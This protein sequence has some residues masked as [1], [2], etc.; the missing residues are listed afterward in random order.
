LV[1][2]EKTVNEDGEQYSIIS[3]QEPS[4]INYTFKAQQAG[5]VYLYI[6]TSE[7]PKVEVTFRDKNLGEYLIADN[8]G[9]MPLGTLE[10][11]ET[12]SVSI[13]MYSDFKASSV[14]FFYDDNGEL[15]R[16][17]QQIASQQVRVDNFKSSRFEVTGEILKENSGLFFL[18]PNQEG[19]V[20]KSDGKNVEYKTV[21]DTFIY[22]P[23]EKGKFA[24][25]VR[26]VPPGL[27]QGA[28][29]TLIGILQLASV[30]VLKKKSFKI[31]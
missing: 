25:S 19:W 20:I 3:V 6:D 27:Y 4:Y 2:V 17:S 30:L 26:F 1:N 28:A 21:L 24:I 31:E 11:D 7:L 12:A 22:L 29:I 15:E 8:F 13:K 10:E 23:M 14:Q 16:M 9:I 18:V 5:N